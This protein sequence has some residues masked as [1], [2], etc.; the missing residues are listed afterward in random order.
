MWSLSGQIRN[1]V[2]HVIIQKRQERPPP[3]AR[4]AGGQ[5]RRSRPRLVSGLLRGRRG[6]VERHRGRRESPPPEEEVHG[7]AHPSHCLRAQQERRKGEDQVRVP[8]RA[9][10]C[11]A[12]AACWRCR[13]VR[14]NFFRC[15]V[16]RLGARRERDLG[17][18][19]CSNSSSSW[20][21][22]YRP[23]RLDPAHR[24]LASAAVRF[25]CK[26]T[27][28]TF[29]QKC[30]PQWERSGNV[31]LGT[32]CVMYSSTENK[33]GTT[34]GGHV[35]NSLFSPPPSTPPRRSFPFLDDRPC[36]N[37]PSMHVKT[38]YAAPSLPFPSP[39][40]LSVFL[41]LVSLLFCVHAHHTTTSLCCASSCLAKQTKKKTRGRSSPGSRVD[42]AA[43]GRRGGPGHVLGEAGGP[44]GVHLG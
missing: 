23:S 26:F 25:V 33:S 35:I 36:A 43:S 9:V 22:S 8:C 3:R 16:L 27:Y 13:R 4:N 14:W 41:S 6:R 21:R 29:T 37:L 19:Y 20:R 12:R 42:E 17:G 40:L 10:L 18:S 7:A 2:D 28:L 30:G 5:V 32:C 38:D 31:L 11:R 39:T 1:L 15:L 44:D 24:S 34:S